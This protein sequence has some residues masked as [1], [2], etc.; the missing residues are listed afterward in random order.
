MTD[1]VPSVSMAMMEEM[2][3]ARPRRDL[4]RPV[5][6]ILVGALTRM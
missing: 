1:V 5:H 4:A 3:G 2:S 6:L